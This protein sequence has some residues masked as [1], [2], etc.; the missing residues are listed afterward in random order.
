MLISS[1]FISAGLS[2][3]LQPA[4]TARYMESKKVPMVPVALGAA[5]ALEIGAGA[6]LLLGYRH[7][8]AAGLLA[9]FLVPTS[10]LMHDFWNE[11]EAQGRQMQVVNFLKNLAIVG[12][13]L[14]VAVR[15]SGEFSLDSRRLAARNGAL[16]SPD[17]LAGKPN[18]LLPQA[19]G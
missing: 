17:R 11:K 15:G 8:A 9:A 5:A 3:L 18:E 1:V 10:L 13:L 4:Q 16:G 12:G 14:E 6:S 7:R 19:A 2:K